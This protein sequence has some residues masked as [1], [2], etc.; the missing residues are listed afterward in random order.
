MAM[1][2]G[3]PAVV[4]AVGGMVAGVA[5]AAVAAARTVVT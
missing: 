2:G 3:V 5:G 4:N 1:G